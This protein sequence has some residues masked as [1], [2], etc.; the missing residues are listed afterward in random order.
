MVV[1]MIYIFHFFIVISLYILFGRNNQTKNIF[2][3]SSFIYVLFVFGQRWMTGTDFPNYL[4]YFITDFTRQEW[5]YFGLQNLLSHFDLYFGLL[6]I[7]VLFITQINFYRFFL[8]IN[9]QAPLM[10]AIFLISEMFFGQLSQIR[11]YAAISFYLNS[12]YYAHKNKYTKSIFN[13][14]LGYSFHSVALYLLPFLFIKTPISKKIALFFF[15]SAL[16]FP[17]ID[18]HIIFNLPVISDYIRYMGGHFDQPLGFGHNIKYY[19][20]LLVVIYYIQNLKPLPKNNMNNFILNGL[21]LYFLI[22]GFSFHF[23]PVFRVA[24]F[25][26]AFEIIFLIGYANQLKYI[27]DFVSKKIV[28]C[29]FFGIFCFSSLVDSYNVRK[30]QFRPLR[31]Y[32]ERTDTELIYELEEFKQRK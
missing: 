18:I 20:M 26:Q 13:L 12:Y 9:N 11:Q 17:L 24:T 29:L 10:I 1:F 22:Y 28:V 3:V 6:I 32:E 23:A 19:S 5:G 15:I 25:F 7:I 21:I 14:I 16:F 31:V 27:P 8:K 4:R 2:I 30:Y